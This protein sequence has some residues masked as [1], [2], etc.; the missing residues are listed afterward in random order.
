MR[1]AYVSPV[2]CSWTSRAQ[3]SLVG[4]MITFCCPRLSESYNSHSRCKYS[5]V[6]TL[7]KIVYEVHVLHFTL[8]DLVC[9]ICQKKVRISISL[10]TNIHSD[11]CLIPS[12]GASSFNGADIRDLRNEP[13]TIHHCHH[14]RPQ[15][16][17][18]LRPF[19]IS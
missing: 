5:F 18:I 8:F 10:G 17:L 7:I 4:L 6:P 19:S 15:F 9:L 1:R 2:I 12:L 14:K 11:H 3:S 16:I 13:I